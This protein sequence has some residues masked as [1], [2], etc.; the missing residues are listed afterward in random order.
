MYSCRS[1]HS[2]EGRQSPPGSGWRVHG[3]GSQRDKRSRRRPVGYTYLHVAIDDYSR[4]AYVEAHDNETA[5]TLVGFWERAQSWFWS[6][7]LPPKS[8]RV[9]LGCVG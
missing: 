9:G 7:E 1:Q 4:V 5:A 6:N 3:R 8:W 2:Q